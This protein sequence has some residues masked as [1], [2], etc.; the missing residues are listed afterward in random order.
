MCKFKNKLLASA[1]IVG[2]FCIT[3]VVTN[4][5]T[6]QT[7][8]ASATIRVGK[9]NDCTLI[10]DPSTKTLHIK[11]GDNGNTLGKTPLYRFIYKAK[12]HLS[13]KRLLKPTDVKHLSIDRDISVSG[14]AKLLFAKLSNLQDIIG[15][16]KVDTKDVTTMKQMFYYDIK[17]KSLDL[18]TWNTEYDYYFQ[19]YYQMFYNDRALTNLNLDSFT[20]NDSDTKMFHGVNKD[21]IHGIKSELIKYNS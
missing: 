6:E 21:A 18:S 14:S 17:L 11:D 12:K 8:Q 9:S 19:Y 1:A 20:L 10:Y 15:T 13:K 7:V 16:D 4:V 3:A 5:N 2:M